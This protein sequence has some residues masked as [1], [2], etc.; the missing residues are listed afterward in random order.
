MDKLKSYIGIAAAL[1]L[2]FLFL[3]P[4]PRAFWHYD[5]RLQA[6]PFDD[7]VLSLILQR[8]NPA[9]KLAA[10]VDTYARRCPQASQSYRQDECQW[11][12]LAPG[13][14]QIVDLMDDLSHDIPDLGRK[15]QSIIDDDDLNPPSLTALQKEIVALYPKIIPKYKRSYSIATYA[16]HAAFI[17]FLIAMLFWRNATGAILVGIVV[18]PLKAIGSAL[19]AFHKKV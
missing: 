1:G 2:A 9:Y 4:Q 3:W 13:L 16:L 17:A 11:Y 18:E 6:T 14:L 8:K 7:D 15:V 19:R 5:S 12:N 10:Q